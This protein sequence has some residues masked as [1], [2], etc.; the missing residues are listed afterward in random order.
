MSDWLIHP[1]DADLGRTLDPIQGWKQLELV[2]RYNQP[3]AWVLT[4]GESIDAFTPGMGAVLYRDGEFVSSGQMREYDKVVGVDQTGRR[5]VQMTLGFVSDTDVLASRLCLQQ[6]TKLLTSTPSTMSS[7]YDTRTGA[8]EAIILG[9]INANLGP[10]AI[11]SRRMAG[12]VVPASLGRGGTS[13]FTARTDNLALAV[14][15]LAEAGRLRVRVVHDE[16]TGTPR[17]LVVVEEVPDVS[18][19][20]FF[21]PVESAAPGLFETWHFNY[22]QP[23]LTRG[24]VGAGG[25]KLDRLYAQVTDPAAEAL[26]GRSREAYIDQRQTTDAGEIV[27]A[28][29]EALTDGA[30][31]TSVEFGV[32]DGPDAQ[33]RV[34]YKV[35]SKVGLRLPGL[36]EGL[37]D[38][39][40][41][42]AT[43]TVTATAAN[44]ATETVKVL[45]G[46]G[47]AAANNTKQSRDI[48]RALRAVRTLERST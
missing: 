27:D 3:D 7:V 2:E 21:G 25:E 6:P 16:S 32:L 40:V 23:V 43:T 12:L 48:I 17:L 35:G 11:A 1:R 9:Y 26:W 34:H 33:Y 10:G 28:A 8:R 41:R 31:P 14:Q 29:N 4:G 13:R 30:T 5:T 45:V 39:V 36:P 18:A 19:D 37:A 24:I 38:N 42:E 22:K 46:T 15:S 20:V 44:T 47:G